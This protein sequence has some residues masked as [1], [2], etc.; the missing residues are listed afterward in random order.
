VSTRSLLPRGG[1]QIVRIRMA[2]RSAAS[3]VR[4]RVSVGPRITIE[5]SSSPQAEFGVIA[6]LAG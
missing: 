2:A 6:M 1:N 3:S 5:S 4:S